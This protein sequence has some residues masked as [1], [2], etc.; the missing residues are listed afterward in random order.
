MSIHPYIGDRMCTYPCTCQCNVLVHERR[1]SSARTLLV[2]SL[3]SLSRAVPFVQIANYKSRS[4]WPVVKTA[5]SIASGL[6]TFFLGVQWVRWSWSRISFLSRESP[7]NVISLKLCQTLLCVNKC[8]VIRNFIR[9]RFMTQNI[10][11]YHVSPTY[12]LSCLFL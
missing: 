10:G 7:K 2:H 4:L 6:D 1:K 8:L 12:Y 11:V 9:T 3:T 5:N